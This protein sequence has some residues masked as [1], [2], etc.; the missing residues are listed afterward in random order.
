MKALPTVDCSPRSVDK[1]YLRVIL[2]LFLSC[3]LVLLLFRFFLKLILLVRKALHH[4][5]N[6]QADAR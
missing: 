5:C 6:H 4:V 1:W 3:S 2:L